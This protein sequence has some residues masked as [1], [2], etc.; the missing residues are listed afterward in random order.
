[1]PV[2][3]CGDRCIFGILVALADTAATTWL[4]DTRDK[5]ALVCRDC[6]FD[7][8]HK[9]ACGRGYDRRCRL[10]RAFRLVV[11]AKGQLS[12]MLEIVQVFIFDLLL[13]WLARGLLVG[14]IVCLPL[15]LAPKK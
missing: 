3:A 7:A 11:K 13:M 8:V 6:V 1:M 14:D 9:T 10:G 15:F 4:P 5:R 12:H 2:I